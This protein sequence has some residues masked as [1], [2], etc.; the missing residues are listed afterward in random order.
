MRLGGKPYS[1]GNSRFDNLYGM[2][3]H[4]HVLNVVAV[5]GGTHE[6]V[7]GTLH[8]H[9]LKDVNGLF[10]FCDSVSHHPSRCATRSGACSGIF[11]GGE[12]SPGAQTDRRIARFS[13]DV[14]KIRESGQLL[15]GKV[16]ISFL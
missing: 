15:P 16:V 13:R 7:A 1:E 3:T 10:R 5:F 8:L 12:E 4:P 9:T 14:V 6:N 11:A 2:A